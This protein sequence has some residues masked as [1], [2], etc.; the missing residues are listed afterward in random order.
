[1][2]P[3]NMKPILQRST[4]KLKR[5]VDTTPVSGVGKGTRRAPRRVENPAATDHMQDRVAAL[6]AKVFQGI[7]RGREA[8]IEIGRA[9]N[10][11]KKI[12]G[13][14]KWQ[15]HFVETFVPH[16]LALRTAERYMKL[17]EA[18]ADSKIDKMAVFE[19]AKDPAAVKVRNATEQ[20]QMEADGAVHPL[21][22][23]NQVYKLTLHLSMDER[24]AADK[25][26]RSPYRRQAEKKI[27][28]FLKQLYIEFRICTR[29]RAE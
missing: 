14:G 16:G 27:I 20:A 17:A 5:M 9:L 28:G 8:N 4:R 1:M 21:P 3:K 6:D 11:Q 22:E 18:E 24:N 10:E 25:L 12:L 15:R 26:W 23:P 19:S 2:N 29:R 13:H 7:A